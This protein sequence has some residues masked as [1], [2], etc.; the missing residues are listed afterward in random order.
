M[1]NSTKFQG[2]P[3]DFKRYLE[4]MISEGLTVDIHSLIPLELE[5]SEFEFTAIQLLTIIRLSEKLADKLQVSTEEVE[6]AFINAA[7]NEAI[8]MTQSEK[9]ELVARFYGCFSPR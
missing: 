9:M 8:G 1:H 7:C 2:T 6:V 4:A 5:G 3:D